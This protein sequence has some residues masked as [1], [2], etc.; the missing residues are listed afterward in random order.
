[1][2]HPIPLDVLVDADKITALQNH[3]WSKDSHGYYCAKIKRKRVYMHRFILFGFEHSGKPEVDHANRN[4]LDNRI[5]NLRLCSRRQN[6][7][8]R[9]PAR[10]HKTSIYKGVRFAKEKNRWRADITVNGRRI[11][12][13]LFKCERDAARAYDIASKE[14]NGEF[15]Y[16]NLG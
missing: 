9:G 13:G 8:N 12:L 5:E 1:M 7:V 10:I 15:A 4:P 2:K 16:L 6:M 3:K 14:H 11:F